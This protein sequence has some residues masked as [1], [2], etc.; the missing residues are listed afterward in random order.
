MDSEMDLIET[1][2]EEFIVLQQILVHICYILSLYVHL[3][4]LILKA[5]H[6]S[7]YAFTWEKT[8]KRSRKQMEFLNDTINSSHRTIVEQLRMSRNCFGVLCELLRTLGGVTN[9]R[10]TTVEAQVA[11]FLHILAGHFKN[12]HIKLMYNRSGETVSRHFNRVLR[13]VLRLQGVLLVQPEPV[14]ANSTD[15]KWKWFEVIKYIQDIRN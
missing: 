10:N 6:R 14:P 12:R 8:H 2:A 7:A 5:C 1:E 4:T 3:M 9:T 13:G 11:M 15:E